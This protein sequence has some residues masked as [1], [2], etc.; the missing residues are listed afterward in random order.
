MK[1]PVNDFPAGCKRAG[2]FLCAMDSE[3][4]KV[5]FALVPICFIICFTLLVYGV[6]RE[7][8]KEKFIDTQNNLELLSLGS[9]AIKDEDVFFELLHEGI[10]YID[11]LPHVFAALYDSDLVILLERHPEAGTAPF[12]PRQNKDFMEL[13]GSNQTG[14][15]PI[16]WEDLAGGITRRKMYTCFRWVTMPEINKSYLMAAGVSAYSIASPTIGLLIGIVLAVLLLCLFTSLGV[17]IFVVRDLSLHFRR[18]K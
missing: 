11:D 2:R 13:V 7:K 10:E 9:N 3:Q 14:T 6:S 1:E 12:D 5:V 8:L 15:I 17:V 18:C 4:K 16:I